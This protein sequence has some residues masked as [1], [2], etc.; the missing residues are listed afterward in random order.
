[1]RQATCPSPV[2]WVAFGPAGKAIPSD[3]K[4][5]VPLYNRRASAEVLGQPFDPAF[6]RGNTP[7]ASRRILSRRDSS[8]IA[9]PAGQSER[10]KNWGWAGEC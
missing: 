9:F 7:D 5:V 6:P 2:L 4:A 8:S 10:G 3:S 1:M